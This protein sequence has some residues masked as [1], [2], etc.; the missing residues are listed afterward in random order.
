MSKKWTLTDL[1]DWAA[2]SG[3]KCLSEA[4]EGMNTPHSWQCSRGHS[5]LA[6]PSSVKSGHWCAQCYGNLARSTDDLVQLASMRDGFLLDDGKKDSKRRNHW[7]CSKGHEW[8]ALASSVARGSWCPTCAG[9]SKLSIDAAIAAAHARGGTCLS[10][11]Y[12]NARS[13]M[14]WECAKG[15]QWQATLGKIRSGQWC[16]ICRRE[17][18]ANRLRLTMSDVQARAAE[19]GGRCIS[20]AYGGTAGT[21]L[22]FECG[23]GHRWWA[24]PNTIQRSWCPHCAGKIVT[25]DDLK[26]IANARDGYVVSDQYFGDN[27]RL[28]WRCSLGHEW[29]ATPGSIKSGCW[30]PQCSA[31]LGERLCRTAFEAVFE[32]DFPSSFP[33]WLR[34]GGRT[35]W[36]LDGYCEALSIAFEHHGTYH[37]RVDGVYSKD[38]AALLKRQHDDRKKADLCRLNGVT[39]LTVPEVPRL[40]P[41]EQL[42]PFIVREAQAAGLLVPNPH[43]VPEWNKAYSQ[44][45]PV[46]M[47]QEIAAQKGGVLLSEHYFGSGK[48]LAWRCNRGHEWWANPNSIQQ[49]TWCPYC[50]GSRLSDENRQLR[51]QTMHEE[52]ARRGGQCLAEF[53]QN[54]NTR[55]E[56]ICALGHQW[57]ATPRNVLVNKSWCPICHA[58]SRRKRST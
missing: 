43:V 58:D 54:G 32:A 19:K 5:W 51:L 21:P 7:Q 2:Q 16:G 14:V 35:K 44:R 9:S 46:K 45:D 8:F 24:S 31:G 57:L 34:L 15:H 38:E 47:L 55:V 39:L 41:I 6:L 52:A 26:A 33:E 4:Y 27:R 30:C 23:A 13:P 1:Q 25:L 20:T 28:L 56:W 53:Y 18:A 10:K 29:R 12:I 40:L 37:Y 49:G 48:P 22:E 3:G 36:Q 17:I 11:E 42:V 50:A